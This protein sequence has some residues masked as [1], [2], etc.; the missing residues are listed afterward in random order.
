MQEKISEYT[1]ENEKRVIYSF[2]SGLPNTDL[3]DTINVFFLT[4]FHLY[5]FT[6]KVLFT[7]YIFKSDILNISVLLLS[8][9]THLLII[10]D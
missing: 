1:L 2:F 3:L 10:G 4:V 6:E 8:V 9:L 7:K 5:K